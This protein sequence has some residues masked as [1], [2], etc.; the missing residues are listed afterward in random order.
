MHAREESAAPCGTP[1]A[2]AL[3]P[4]RGIGRTTATDS[5]G[6]PSRL[7]LEESEDL[8]EDLEDALISADFGP[9]SSLKVVDAIR[10]KV[11]SAGLRVGWVRAANTSAGAGVSF[12]VATAVGVDV[13]GRGRS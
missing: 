10:D 4:D 2:R 5:S 3:Q 7:Q 8:L 9:G 12:A 1:C 13:V 11:R 6:G